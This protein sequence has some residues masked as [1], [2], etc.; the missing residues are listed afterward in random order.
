MRTLKRLFGALVMCSLFSLPV[1]AATLCPDG[2]YHADGICKLCP[3]GSWTTA[4]SCTLAPDGNY[5]PDYGRGTRL[6]PD[7][8]Y[9]P[10]T[11][12]MVLCPDGNYYPGRNCRLLPDGRYIGMQQ[13][14][15]PTRPDIPHW[16]SGLVGVGGVV[17][18][19]KGGDYAIKEKDDCGFINSNIRHIDYF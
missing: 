7:G 11:G 16:I 13:E 9:I 15:S 4:P 19:T 10:D 2:Q 14:S 6:A 5:V 8:K 18:T 17:K 12:S 1:S 3:D